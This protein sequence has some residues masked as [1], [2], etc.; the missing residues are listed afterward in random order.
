MSSSIIN[1]YYI[2]A[3]F[4]EPCVCASCGIERSRR[5]APQA[6]HRRRSTHTIFRRSFVNP[7]PLLGS[8]FSLDS[9]QWQKLIQ[10]NLPS[11]S[12]PEP[13]PSPLLITVRLDQKNFCVVFS[14]YSN[15]RW[16]RSCNHQ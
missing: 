9:W 8:R 14:D 16:K 6:A 10:P 15:K 11:A 4:K 3:R 7:W 12:Q 1:F 13:Q 5:R 2:Q